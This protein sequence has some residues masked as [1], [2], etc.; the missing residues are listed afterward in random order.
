MGRKTNH[1]AKKT[2]KTTACQA[3]MFETLEGRTMFS[4]TP[5]AEM[6][7]L[8]DWKLG[9]TTANSIS[10]ANWANLTQINYFSLTV[11]QNG[12]LPGYVSTSN[13]AGVTSASGDNAT[14]Q[15]AGIESL[16]A[17]HNSSAKVFVSVGGE[18]EVAAMTALIDHPSEYG[19]FA[20]EMKAFITNTHTAGV[21]LDWEPTQATKAEID[22]FAT[23]ITTL[24][25]QGLNVTAAVM[26]DTLL[27]VNSS[28]QP[29]DTNGNPTS[30]DVWEYELNKTAVNALSSI[31]V[32]AYPANSE[33]DANADMTNWN[34]YLS[35]GSP[36]VD[37]NTINTALSKLQYGLDDE[38]DTTNTPAVVQDKVNMSVKD[39]YS[40]MFLWDLQGTSSST[41]IS[42]I[43]ADQPS[44]PTQPVQPSTGA[45]SGTITSTTGAG[46]AGVTVYLDTN[47]DSK[48]D[49]G[50]LTATTNT[51]GAY[52]F[53]NVP[54]GA[55]IVRQVLP[56][57]DTQ[58][59]PSSNY[60]IH[61]TVSAGSSLTGENF[62][63][64]VPAN[65]NPTGSAVQLSG[66]PIGTAG[67]YNNGGNTIAKVF[68]GNSS[69]F[70][71]APTAGSASSPDWVGLDLGSEHAI[72]Q[73]KYIARS[74]YEWRMEG[75]VFQGANNANFSDAVN[76]AT[77]GN[78]AAPSST[79]FNDVS[80]SGTFR[81]VRYVAPTGAYG[82]IAEMQVW[83]SSA[84]VTNN[85][86]SN[87]AIFSNNVIGLGD[88]AGVDLA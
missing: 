23:L 71:D 78:T 69:T 17:S 37:G 66:T 8:Q 14:Q 57:G 75:G 5:L 81:Y 61:L 68:D 9:S 6:G 29:V 47:N 62:V 31:E 36:D 48:L 79:S 25:G 39:G 2:T 60:G 30:N 38:D 18:T 28:N 58:K 51:S 64:T 84:A 12:N 67:S 21:D 16:I 74:G 27:L 41:I 63:D 19:T 59:T 34:A 45:V 42:E 7:Y 76:L 52:N 85:A 26:G 77:I 46:I 73:I 4:A 56:S 35:G 43:A 22:G 70:F 33:A 72:T 44:Q 13:T 82:N 1:T 11:D 55:T 50:E 87:N 65:I 83:G 49:N 24:Q 10:S 20:S 86:I 53:S 3:S 88:E 40:G 54:V 15:I 80:V 32:M